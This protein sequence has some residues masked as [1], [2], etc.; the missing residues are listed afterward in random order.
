MAARKKK[1]H[2][3]GTREKIRVTQLINRLQDCAF[4]TVEMTP[5]QMKA[6]EICLKKALPDLSQIEQHNTSDQTT[7][8]VQVPSPVENPADWER[9]AEETAVKALEHAL[10]EPNDDE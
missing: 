5:A 2:D 8:L 4:G 1:T 3:E 7:Y 6:A 10:E 9:L